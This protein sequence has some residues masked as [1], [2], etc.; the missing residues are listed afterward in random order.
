[1][2]FSAR[3]MLNYM[4]WADKQRQLEEAKMDQREA[5]AFELTTYHCKWR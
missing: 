5:L 4:D 2:A 1:M 3:G